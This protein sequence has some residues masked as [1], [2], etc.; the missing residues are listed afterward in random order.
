[1]DIGPKKMFAQAEI[2]GN[3]LQQLAAGVLETTICLGEDRIEFGQLPDEN[4][5]GIFGL[6]RVTVLNGLAEL[7]EFFEVGSDAA[8]RMFLPERSIAPLAGEPWDLV[9]PLG[10]LRKRKKSGRIPVKTFDRRVGDAMILHRYE[11]HFFI[12]FSECGYKGFFLPG[13]TGKFG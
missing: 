1:M 7:E 9:L 11:P 3:R 4:I 10:F 13:R 6:D 8:F 2:E 12:R 5:V